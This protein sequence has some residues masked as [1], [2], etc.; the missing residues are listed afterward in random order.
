MKAFRFE[1]PGGPE[2][3]RFDDVPLPEPGPG[4]VRIQHKAVALKFRDIWCGAASMR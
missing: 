4:E 1:R 3:L 2:V